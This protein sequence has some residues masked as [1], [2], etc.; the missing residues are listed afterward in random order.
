M[1]NT[2]SRDT[3]AEMA[4]RRLVHA[5][6]LRYRVDARPERKV[7]RRADMVFRSAKV[8]VFVDGCFWHACPVHGSSPKANSEWWKEKLR[9]NVARDADTNR[10]LAELGWTVIRVWEHATPSEAADKIVAAVRANLSL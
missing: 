9:V 1:R 6:G 3:P 4:I 8:A 2:P 7:N 10:R 5:A